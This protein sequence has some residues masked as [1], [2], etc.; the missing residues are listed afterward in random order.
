VN[1]TKLK[2]K[3]RFNE[4]LE[5]LESRKSYLYEKFGVIKF[6]IF[7]SFIRNENN[8]KSDLD[9]V[10][11]LLPEKKDIHNFLELKRFLEKELGVRVDIGFEN[12]IKPYIKEKIK[13]KI[14][15][16]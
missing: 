15:Y 16:V 12:A 2:K 9:I 8:S 1:K 3:K 10:V 6:G 7:G 14:V 13:D 5:Y 11:E 4:I